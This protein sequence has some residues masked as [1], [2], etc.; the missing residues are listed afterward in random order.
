MDLKSIVAD[1][2]DNKDRLDAATVEKY[3][4]F[5]QNFLVKKDQLE[6][7]QILCL[8][9]LC[10]LIAC[11]SSSLQLSE[12]LS[13]ELLAW[14]FDGVSKINSEDHYIV[15]RNLELKL[16]GN[17]LSSPNLGKVKVLHL[18]DILKTQFL[19]ENFGEITKQ[20]A[21]E[22]LDTT[23]MIV[24]SVLKSRYFIDWVANSEERFGTVLNS[25]LKV[26]LDTKRAIGNNFDIILQFSIVETLILSPKLFLNF[27]P[28]MKLFVSEVIL[29]GSESAENYKDS[30]ALFVFIQLFEPL[31]EKLNIVNLIFSDTESI[32]LGNVVK[33]FGE[34]SVEKSNEINECLPQL[35]DC[36]LTMLKSCRQDKRSEDSNSL[37]ENYDGIVSDLTRLLANLVYKNQQ[38]QDECYDYLPILLENCRIDENNSFLMEWNVLL[39]RNMLEKN[40]RN[41]KFVADLQAKQVLPNSF[42]ENLGLSEALER[43]VF[44]K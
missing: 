8:K 35:C 14:L 20:F 12:M 10:N 11:Y 15:Q 28:E 2:K 3:F 37:I 7:D 27:E 6:N 38:K 40:C 22:L 23:F 30:K 5:C 33:I 4:A 19:N 39:I 44:N 18:C 26:T 36:V 32:L 42:V 34:M 21:R 31:F 41:Q 25:I 43:R 17:I 24:N 9:C 1:F 16:I 13:D 29:E